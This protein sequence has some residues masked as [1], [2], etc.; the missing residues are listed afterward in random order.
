MFKL[1]P[2]ISLV[3]YFV[4]LYVSVC[5]MAEWGEG[6]I[7]VYADHRRNFLRCT[8]QRHWHQAN[9]NPIGEISGAHGSEY[10]DDILLGRCSVSAG[11]I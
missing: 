3:E 7:A 10:E 5:R 9:V 11:R 6:I 2:Y 8:T 1:G 4:D